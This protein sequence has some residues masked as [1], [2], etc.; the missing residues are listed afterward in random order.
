MIKKIIVLF[1]LISSSLIANAQDELIPPNPDNRKLGKHIAAGAF[2]GYG[3]T[4]FSYHS[5][6]YKP[7]K[8]ILISASI[9][10]VLALS[11]EALDKSN[12]FQPDKYDVVSTIGGSII[13]SLVT[14][15][16]CKLVFK[17]K[18][19]RKFKTIR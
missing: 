4:L 5:E 18:N 6:N 19:T 11:K 9:S 3:V 13:G 2:I 1:T 12:G 14:H 16:L 17:K 15:Q 10:A 8:A 7:A